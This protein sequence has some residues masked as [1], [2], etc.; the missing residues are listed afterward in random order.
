MAP[1]TTKAAETGLTITEVARDVGISA[2]Q[3]TVWEA[4]Y[5]WPKPE[6]RQQYHRRYSRNQVET[7]RLV[8]A[9]LARGKTIGEVLRDPVLRILDGG[10]ALPP[11]G[12]VAPLTFDHIPPP[13]TP[14]GQRLR[15][16]L[17]VAL[18]LGE[19]GKIQALIAQAPLI[20]PSDR[21]A[22]ITGP[23]DSWLA[24]SASPQGI[25]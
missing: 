20:R 5:G 21:F 15:K 4:R 11:K 16:Q 9:Q 17:E 19:S 25:P 12:P 2:A 3:L 23:Y 10:H 14:E 24:R 22:A 13:A 18:R 7:L 8:A 6:R 1:R